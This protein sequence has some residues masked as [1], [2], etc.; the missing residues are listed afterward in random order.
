[1]IRR[2]F[3][4]W[5]FLLLLAASWGP[6][7]AQTP[8][9]QYFNESGHNVQGE[10]LQFYNAAPNPMLVYGYPITE[11]MTSR[12]GKTVQY[13]QR[14]RFEYDASMPEGQRV[15][16]SSL[17][18]EMYAPLPSSQ[19]N[20]FSPLACRYYNQSGYAVCFAFLEFFDQHGG[21]A[22]FGYPISPFEYHDSLLV[23][24]FEKARLEWRPWMDETQRVAV[25]DLGRAYFERLGEDIALLNPAQPANANIQPQ[26]LSLQA[27]AFVWKAATLSTDQQ[28]VFIIA[29][30]QTSRPISKADCVVTVHWPD[31]HV[32]ATPIKTDDKGIA[33]A[34]FSFADQPYGSLIY[35]D[36]VCSF[37]AL[38]GSTTT[39]FR[40]WY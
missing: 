31:G 8:D 33:I 20:L 38:Q 39:S 15:R 21:V 40:I 4:L 12:D 25:T 18:S 29:Q 13:F 32:D 17:G 26:A 30:D 11:Q 23:Q 2:S 3:A 34:S 10:F 24:Y 37:N 7:R 22:Q 5:I 9:I 36:V 35:V 27:R 16:A 1:M 28:T 19:L 6:V 14:A